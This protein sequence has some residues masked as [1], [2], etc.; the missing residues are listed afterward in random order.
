VPELAAL[1]SAEAVLTSTVLL[2]EPPVVVVTPFPETAAQP[3]TPVV[4]VT[5]WQLPF[6]QVWPVAQRVPHAPQLFT[7]LA[8]AMHALL[9]KV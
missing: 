2:V 9:Q 1:E 3:M 6:E 4:I 5:P 7:S 8:V